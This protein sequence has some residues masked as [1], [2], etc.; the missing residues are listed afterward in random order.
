M[1]HFFC[2]TYIVS[3]L[4]ILF[5]CRMA[6]N[7]EKICENAVVWDTSIT[8]KTLIHKYPSDAFVLTI[9]SC[10]LLLLGKFS[11]RGSTSY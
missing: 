2:F 8:S 10:H 4:G 6:S 3:L 1:A 11:K 7:T 5:T 9:Y